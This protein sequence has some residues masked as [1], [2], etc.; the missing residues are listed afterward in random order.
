M[1]SRCPLRKVVYICVRLYKTPHRHSSPGAQMSS[2]RYFALVKI[3]D[4]PKTY[5][6]RQAE[7]VK[8]MRLTK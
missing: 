6:V 4:Y 5:I 3:R 2:V 8:A 1:G 7:E